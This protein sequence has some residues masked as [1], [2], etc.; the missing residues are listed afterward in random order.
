MNKFEEIQALITGFSMA[1]NAEEVLLEDAFN[2]ILQ[3]DV[4]AD[5]DMPP[6]NKSAMDG[7]ACRIEDIGNEL[8]VLEV[9]QA[10]MV[11]SKR[12]GKNQC[13]KIMTGAAVPSGCDCVFKVEDSEL[14]DE[15]RVRCTNPKTA[16]NI[17]YQGED[18]QTGD[19]LI[20][21]GTIIST[22]QMAVLAGAG[23]SHVRVSVRPRITLIATGSELVST[24]EKPRDGQIRNSNTS[25][26]LTQ[27]KKMNLDV[28]AN[29]MLV[30]DYEEL[31]KIFGYS[32]ETS[33]IIIFTGGASVGDFDFVPEILKE[34]GFHIYW[35]RT[36]I[37]PGNPMTFSQKDNKF[38]IG[39]SG[40]PVSSLAQFEFIA[41]PVIYKLLG[42]N[43]K[44][45]RIQCLMNFEFSRKNADRLAVIPVMI[46]DEGTIDEIPFH[47]S[48]H[49]N[50]LVNANALLEVPFDVTHIN[51]GT[52]AYVRPL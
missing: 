45:L 22:P 28:I 44:A 43:Y 37:K 21:K 36:G 31:S 14:A 48:A 9:I 32:L 24:S 42:A 35:D 8:E 4:I 13:V 6:F 39:L 15:T 7:F 19:V 30:D 34:E 1:L 27:L 25:Q 46:N 17:C 23:Y 11:S 41:K 49:I 20:K 26:V 16:L 40:N 3:E 5:M 33:D 12:V 38:V 10:G 51:K 47:G 18:Y 29:L 50:A 2:R 52:F